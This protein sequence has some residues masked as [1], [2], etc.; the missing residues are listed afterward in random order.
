MSTGITAILSEQNVID[1]ALGTAGCSSGWPTN[2]FDFIYNNSAHGVAL[3]SNYPYTAHTGTCKSP[4]LIAP[5]VYATAPLGYKGVSAQSKT[6][7]LYVS[8]AWYLHPPLRS[9]GLAMCDSAQ[10]GAW[11]D[12]LAE[13]NRTDKLPPPCCSKN[14][15]T[16]QGLDPN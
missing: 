16:G 1:C 15:L 6:Q 11:H 3:S 9:L 13:P 7:M 8:S 5:P 4:S 12:V 10:T 2:A 14:V